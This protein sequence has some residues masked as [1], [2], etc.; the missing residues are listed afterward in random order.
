MC[1][2]VLHKA[3]ACRDTSPPR[4]G[5]RRRWQTWEVAPQPAAVAAT[6][7]Q[8]ASRQPRRHHWG[9]TSHYSTSHRHQAG[10]PQ[11]PNQTEGWGGSGSRTGIGGAGGEVHHFM[12]WMGQGDASLKGEIHRQYGFVAPQRQRLVALWV[13]CSGPPCALALV[14]LALWVRWYPLGANLSRTHYSS[15]KL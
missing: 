14:R 3:P 5:Y 10:P 1:Q 12:G 6:P 2:G 11:Q 9:A 15:L 7:P 4:M 13:P 8:V